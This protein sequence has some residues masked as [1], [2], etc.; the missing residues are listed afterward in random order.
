[1]RKHS[2]YKVTFHGVDN[3]Q[4]FQGHGIAMTKFDD[5]AT[6]IGFSNAEAFDDALEQLATQGWN[7]EALEQEII[8]RSLDG[9][10]LKDKPDMSLGDGCR[11]YISVDVKV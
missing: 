10:K 2:D 7:A 9:E 3:A 8:A 5:C 11:Y 1:M 4:Y 6:G